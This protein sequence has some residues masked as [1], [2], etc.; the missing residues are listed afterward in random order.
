MGGRIT[1]LAFFSNNRLDVQNSRIM[2]VSCHSQASDRP[3]A[4][5]DK[6]PEPHGVSAIR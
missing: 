6:R 5:R 1:P 3:V 2:G 4:R